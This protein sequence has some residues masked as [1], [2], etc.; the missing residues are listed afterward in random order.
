MWGE[1]LIGRW[2]EQRPE[3]K[4]EVAIQ[5]D[6]Q[7]LKPEERKLRYSAFCVLFCKTAPAVPGST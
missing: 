4:T 7:N 1:G 5:K 3:I 6:P 2:P